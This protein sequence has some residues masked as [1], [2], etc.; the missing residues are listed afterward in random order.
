MKSQNL[1]LYLYGSA[2][3]SYPVLS[4]AMNNMSVCALFLKRLDYAISNLESLIQEN[5]KEFMTPNTVFN[6]CTLYDLSTSPEL[7]LLKK[8]TL[9]KI[10]AIYSVN[11]SVVPFQCYRLT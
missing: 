4:I 11:E 1:P 9:H 2:D 7:S 6:L 10:A 8:T 3:L 5:P